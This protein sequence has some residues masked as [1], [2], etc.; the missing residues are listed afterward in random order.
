MAWTN[1]RKAGSY[2]PPPFGAHFAICVGVYEIG[3][4]TQVYQGKSRTAEKVVLVFELPWALKD[5][6]TP[7]TTSEFY[8][9]SLYEKARLRQHLNG[10][11]GRVLAEDECRSFDPHT[12]LGAWAQIIVGP[13]GNDKTEISN[14]LHP[15]DL[16]QYDLPQPVNTPKFFSVHQWD[17]ATFETFSDRMK[18]IIM[19]SAEYQAQFAHQFQANPAPAPSGPSAGPRPAAA[20]GGPQA[21]PRPMAAPAAAPVPAAAAPATPP[22]PSAAPRPGPRAAAPGGPGQRP[23][24]PA[25]TAPGVAEDDIPF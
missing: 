2:T 21:G 10:W 4:Q 13:R 14:I 18:A 15:G 20:P 11:Y 9:L 24:V 8:T 16:S 23:P 6:H 17:Q 1:E 3:T 19:E 25:P 12:L 5:D 7:I 22:T